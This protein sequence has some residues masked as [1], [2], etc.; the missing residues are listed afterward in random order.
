MR[1]TSGVWGQRPQGIGVI[2]RDKKSQ[3]AH[4]VES[5]L[6]LEILK[7]FNAGQ[8][9][10]AT[11]CERLQVGRAHLYR[12]R[13]EWLK[14]KQ[15]F[16][17]E[18]SGGN[19]KKFWPKPATDFLQEILPLSKPLNYAFIADQLERRFQFKRARSTVA[20]YIQ[21]H[22]P[23]LLAQHPPGPKPRRRWEC[24]AIGELYQHDSSPHQWWPSAQK[25]ALILTADDHSR[26]MWPDAS[27]PIRPGVISTSSA[28]ASKSMACPR[29]FTPMD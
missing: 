8:M 2:V 11:A 28:R 7:L 21:E 12:L 25:Q 24:A 27:M 16:E 18:L 26:R 15:G 9:D 13:T 6:V 20:D 5:N 10:A 14:N 23:V 22:Y 29:A 4:R 1:K 17:P 3:L 19:H